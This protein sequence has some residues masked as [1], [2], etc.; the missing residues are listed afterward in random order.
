MDLSNLN[1]S[2]IIIMSN[3]VINFL[4]L[5][6][7]IYNRK[8]LSS[9]ERKY[10][11]F[12]SGSDEKNMENLL[13]E[14]IENVKKVQNSNKLNKDT[15]INHK[16]ILNKCLQKTGII[17]YKA[18]EDTGSDQSFS[19]AFLD[20]NDNGLVISSIYGRNIS[21]TFAK[22]INKGESKYA[23]SDEEKKALKEAMSKD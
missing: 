17:R 4:L 6:M 13:I 15:L 20:Q 16:K 11:K 7:V 23:L 14:L 9:L 5:V 8:K 18:F 19:I 12:M 3:T 22:S 10:N 2:S 1:I 21:T